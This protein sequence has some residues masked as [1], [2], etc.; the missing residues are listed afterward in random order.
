MASCLE[1]ES[2]TNDDKLSELQD[3][4]LLHILSFV[5]VQDAVRTSVL[6][7]RW[8]YLRTALPSIHLLCEGFSGSDQL[9]PSDRDGCQIDTCENFVHQFLSER[10]PHTNVVVLCVACLCSNNNV[11]HYFDWDF[12]GN[13]SIF[14]EIIDY[15]HS[16]DIQNFSILASCWINNLAKLNPCRCLTDNPSTESHVD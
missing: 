3:E 1:K 4:L 13:G 5:D 15:V 2:L 16:T 12:E 6:A 9:D 8:Q 10:D 7:S 11:N 14:E